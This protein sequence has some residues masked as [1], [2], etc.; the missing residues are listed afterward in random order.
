MPENT[1]RPEV[2]QPEHL[3]YL[4]GLQNSG[5]TNMLGAIP[6]LE[7]AYPE[8]DQKTAKEVLIYWI[9][10]YAERHPKN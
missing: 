6:Y 9:K 5:V 7:K 8:L 3:L 2:L 10:T 4:D 1:T